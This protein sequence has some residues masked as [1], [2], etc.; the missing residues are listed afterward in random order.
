MSNLIIPP[1]TRAIVLVTNQCNLACPY[2]FESCSSQ[3]MSLDVAKDVLDFLHKES[4]MAGFTFFGGEPCLEWDNV[5]FPMVEYSKSLDKRTRFSMTTNATLLSSDRVDY[6]IENNISMLLQIDGP[7]ST[8]ESNRPSKSGR[9]SFDNIEYI[10]PYILDRRPGQQVRATV[11]GNSVRN[12]YSD[13]MWFASIGV[14]SLVMLPNLHEEWNDQQKQAFSDQIKMYEDYIV[15]SFRRN[16][17]PIIFE[18]YGQSFK[19][20]AIATKNLGYRTISNCSARNQ[21]GFGIKGSASV[22]TSGNLYGCHRTDMEPDSIWCIGNIYDGVDIAKVEAL[23]GT[24]NSNIVGNKQCSSCP[25]NNI[26]NGGCA[27]N[28]WSVCGD[29]N[30]VPEL[31]CFWTR[32]LADSAYRVCQVLGNENNRLF[33]DVF[34]S[35]QG[36]KLWTNS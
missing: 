13:I 20:V 21:C 28:N 7:R 33:V 32:T 31:F 17:R 2:C 36:G 11:T 22:D 14:R 8:H 25:L 5:I 34:R 4:D 27:S 12:L 23:L 6:L 35:Y 29:V 18:E 15:D 19:R 10:L 9:S 26:C 3:R 24:Y 30:A 1:I 16:V